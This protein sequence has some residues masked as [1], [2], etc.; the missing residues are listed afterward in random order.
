VN[1]V[2]LGPPGSG[3]GTQAAR[4][5]TELRV[6]HVSTGEMLRQA[7]EGGSEL[8]GRVKGILASGMLVPDDVMA[9]VVRERLGASD[10]AGG[11]LLDGYPR[12]LPQGELLDGLLAASGRAV[13]HVVFLD[14]PAD[15]LVRRLLGRGRSDDSVETIERRL[16]EYES[17]TFPL[18][19]RYA[20]RGLLRRIDGT[21]DPDQVLERL[22]AALGW[23]PR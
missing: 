12:T 7:V 15:E 2:F 5:A 6:P 9:G 11:F 8:G 1:V 3:K 22:R 17:K 21:G 14:V 20:E 10:C 19:D 13:D 16:R 4:I 23:T 18:R